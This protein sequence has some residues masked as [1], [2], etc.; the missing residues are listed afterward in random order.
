M[1]RSLFTGVSGLKQEQTKMDVLSNNVA[2]V[3]TTGF[4]K[5]RA[6]FQ[7]LFSQTI[8]NAQQAS[9][10]YGGN[11]AMQVGL[12]V[13]LAS[14]DTIM[15]QGSLETTGKTT[16]LAIEGGGM[17]VINNQSGSKTYTRDG[18]FNINPSYDLAM[19]NTGFK[20]QGWLSTQNSETGQL[21]MKDTGLVPYDINVSKYLK[22][23]AHQTNKV[24][25]ASN[26]DSGSD[27]RDIKM[28]QSTLTFQ[29]SAGNFENLKFQFKKS[30]AQHWSY[31]ATD[32]T[33]G[34]VALGTI[35]T[36]VD[37]K[38]TKTTCLDKNGNQAYADGELP[39]FTYDPDGLPQP[40]TATALT[41]PSQTNVGNGTSMNISASGN[42]VKD[43]TIQVIFDGGDPEQ[44][45]TF[46]VVGSDRGFIGTGVLGGTQAAIEGSVISFQSPSNWS[47]GGTWNPDHDTGFK[48]TYTNPNQTGTPAVPIEATITIP[49]VVVP[50]PA[51]SPQSVT[52]LMNTQLKNAG[53]PALASFDAITKKFKIV[54]DGTGSNRSLQIDPLASPVGSLADL[55]LDGVAGVPSTGN[56]ASK[57]QVIGTPLNNTNN[58]NWT[59]TVPSTLTIPA[60]GLNISILPTGYTSATI[61]SFTPNQTYTRED[62]VTTINTALAASNQNEDVSCTIDPTSQRLILNGSRS[63]SGEKLVISSSS[64]NMDLLGFP[65]GIGPFSY[66][67]T[68]GMS[69]FNQ[70]GI[71]FTLT[72][73]TKAWRPNE[74]L[75]MSTKA[76][77]GMADSVKVNVPNTTT[78]L[79]SFN[80]TVNTPLGEKSFEITGAV[81]KGAVHSTSITTYDS[82]GASHNMVTTWEHT[83]TATKEWTMKI[84]YDPDDTEIQSWVKDPANGVVDATA[85]TTEEL[86]RANDALIKNRKG[87]IY[88]LNNGK[89]DPSKSI[90]PVPETTPQGS[91]T[92]KVTLDP[93]LITE[94]DS[95][96]T[97]AAREQD[98]YEMG[99]LN[100]VYFEQDGTIRG[101]YSNGQKQP[102]GQL[103]MATFNNPGGLEKSGNNLYTSSPNSGA[104]VVGK[105]AT[106]ERGTIV[107]GAL[108]MSNVDIAE[109]FTNLIITQ[110][111][112]Q[113]C[114][115]VI[116]TSDEILQEVVNLK[117]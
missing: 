96:F 61:V 103:A 115:K 98:G 25:Y 31:T 106:G 79:M 27:E 37:G 26:L 19:T 82:L 10:T 33:E 73:G 66:N 14:I 48:V 20:V 109:E 6:M 68:A 60:E 41:N 28:G 42:A 89:I 77:K 29:D 86:E 75:T 59:N 43:E 111:A 97:T 80:T 100:S 74:T 112:F 92:V 99:M 22:K 65:T 40:A 7:D 39:S 34:L 94:F 78:Q 1:I 90:I 5:G 58:I 63:G 2:N 46:R 91:N 15:D 35:E 105:P 54:A 55:G 21:E 38:I 12:G 36:D 69:D 57:P 85:P 81:N 3:N 110:R 32:D 23:F 83:N 113:A 71:K 18:N 62:V 30:D 9:G 101:V 16:D 72:E 116:T 117:R 108:E 88:F 8:K 104:A 11:N 49:A 47:T 50:N 114:S 67:G 87:T 56:G 17:F 53:V 107:P 70:G 95:A 64:G 84:T 102:I 93:A 51:Y 45:N 13:K 4:K 52:A 24:T 44:A 76:E